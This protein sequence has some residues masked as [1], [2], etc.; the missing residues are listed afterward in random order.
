M[1]KWELQEKISCLNNG[2]IGVENDL[3]FWG[4]GGGLVSIRMTCRLNNQ[5]N[6]L[7]E[8]IFYNFLGIHIY[9]H[10][11]FQNIWGRMILHC[12]AVQFFYKKQ[13]IW[14]ELY[15]K[16]LPTRLSQQKSNEKQAKL[17]YLHLLNPLSVSRFVKM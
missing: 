9:K 12:E 8:V 16:Y 6:C 1:T 5:T 7:I 3:F 15:Q 4:G 17:C 11:K 2:Y 13:N 14:G 10:C